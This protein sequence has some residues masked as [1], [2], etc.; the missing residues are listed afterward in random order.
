MFEAKKGMKKLSLAL[1]ALATAFVITPAALADSFSYDFVGSGLDAALTFTATPNAS[2]PG[3]TITGVSGTISA[4]TDIPLTVTFNTATGDTSGP[5]TA[6]LLPDINVP[7]G[8]NCG[9]G[10]NTIGSIQ[11]DQQLFPGNRPDLD[12]GGV[13]FEING[14][15]INVYG[16]GSGYQ[17]TDSGNYVNSTNLS[18]PIMAPEPSSLLLLSTGLLGLAFVLFRRH[19]TS[20]AI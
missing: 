5:G 1:L 4:G 17:W 7:C 15:I 8:F 12:F 3:F 2:A 6:S 18:Q 11:F 10:Y 19:I 13:A 20:S 9:N 14:L 16:V